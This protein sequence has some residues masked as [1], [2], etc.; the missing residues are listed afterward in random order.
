MA[1][2]DAQ[3]AREPRGVD[4]VWTTRGGLVK[5]RRKA[6][7]A[8]VDTWYPE[9]PSSSRCSRTAL[10]ETSTLVRK[11]YASCLR[12]DLEVQ[13]NPVPPPPGVVNSTGSYP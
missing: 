5:E 13:N 4:G 6:G 3:T 9:G 2:A 8:R 12:H 1:A 11:G 7:E 10:V